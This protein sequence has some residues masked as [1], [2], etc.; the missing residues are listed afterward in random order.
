M[1]NL[2]T[3]EDREFVRKLE[4]FEIEPADFNHRSHIRMAYT[5][6]CDHDTKATCLRVRRVLCGLLSHN[7]IKPSAKYHETMT[8]AWAL[9]VRHFMDGTPNTTSADEFIDANPK[10][11]DTEIMKTHYSKELLFSDIARNCFVEPDLAPIP[12][13][14]GDFIEQDS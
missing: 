12:H 11:L 1:A 8:K 14:D 7:D 3:T 9:T 13:Y 6:L 4:A 10:L 2:A 5:Y